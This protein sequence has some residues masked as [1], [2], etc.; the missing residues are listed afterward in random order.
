ML[1]EQSQLQPQPQLIYDQQL[2]IDLRPIYD[3]ELTIPA[4]INWLMQIEDSPYYLAGVTYLSGLHTDGCS[5][6]VLKIDK[7]KGFIPVTCS[8]WM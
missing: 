3:S 4:Q 5:E 1:E 8:L 6:W 2:T 7:E